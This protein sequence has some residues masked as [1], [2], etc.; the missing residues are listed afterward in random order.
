MLPF[1]Q[2]VVLQK[3]VHNGLGEGEEASGNME[4]EENKKEKTQSEYVEQIVVDHNYVQVS[5]SARAYRG[6]L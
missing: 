1:K 3:I 5:M 4:E 6:V 2:E